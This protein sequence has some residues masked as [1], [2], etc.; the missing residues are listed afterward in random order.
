MDMKRRSLLL[1]A[2]PATTFANTPR[3]KAGVFEPAQA[4]PEFAL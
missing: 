2:L 1:A 4:A 3:L